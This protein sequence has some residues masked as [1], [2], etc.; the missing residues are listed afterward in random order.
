MYLEVGVRNSWTET[1][2][3][4]VVFRWIL[5]SCSCVGGKEF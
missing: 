1:R 2:V 4:S 3:Y 5:W